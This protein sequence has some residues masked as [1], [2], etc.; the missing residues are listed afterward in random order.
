MSRPP[1]P[2]P[3]KGDAAVNF[4]NQRTSGHENGASFMTQSVRG[5][6]RMRTDTSAQL[7]QDKQRKAVPVSGRDGTGWDGR[8]SSRPSWWWLLSARLFV[9]LPRSR[10]VR[11]LGAVAERRR[12]VPGRGGRTSIGAAVRSRF[13][14]FLKPGLTLGTRT[15]RLTYFAFRFSSFRPSSLVTRLGSA[16]RLS[17]R[18][19]RCLALGSRQFGFRLL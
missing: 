4:D 8:L 17:S 1:L 7:V 13:S 11:V 5:A 9:C 16:S 10:F 19:L 6:M 3:V 12:A 15:T 2:H 14:V 18:L